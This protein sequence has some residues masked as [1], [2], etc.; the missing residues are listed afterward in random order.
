MRAFWDIP[1]CSLIGVDRYYPD[2]R[3]STHLWNVGLLQWDYTAL[4]PRRL[5]SSDV[6]NLCFISHVTVWYTV[7]YCLKQNHIYIY[8]FFNTVLLTF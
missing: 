2:D 4:Y 5:S 1:L 6:Y 8:F 7:S 3:G